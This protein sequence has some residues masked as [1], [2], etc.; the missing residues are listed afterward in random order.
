MKFFLFEGIHEYYTF[1]CPLGLRRILNNQLQIYSRL[2]IYVAPVKSQNPALCRNSCSIRHMYQVYQVK[3][4]YIHVLLLERKFL[5][6]A[7][8]LLFARIRNHNLLYLKS[9]I[10]QTLLALWDCKVY[11]ILDSKLNPGCTF[12]VLYHTW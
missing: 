11:W 6:K 12:T 10:Q 7:E 3:Q 5:Q 4:T 2:Y 9:C 1:A 8:S